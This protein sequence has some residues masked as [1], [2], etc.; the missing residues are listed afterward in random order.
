VHVRRSLLIASV[1]R[2]FTSLMT[3]ASCACSISSLDA[4]ADDAASSREPGESIVQRVAA[5]AV[6]ARMNL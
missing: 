5:H 1:S 6:V 2:S 4:S 3:D